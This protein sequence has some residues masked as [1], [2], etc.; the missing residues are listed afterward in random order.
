MTAR[1]SRA[2]FALFLALCFWFAPAYAAAQA[3]QLA[4]VPGTIEGVSD[5]EWNDILEESAFLVED[6]GIYTV[7]RYYELEG[8]VGAP[9]AN[10]VF[11]CVG[12]SQCVADMLYGSAFAF[13]LHV[14]VQT[15]PMDVRVTYRLVDVLSGGVS[16]ESTAVLANP[17]D[18]VAL[19]EPCFQA[20]RGERIAPPPAG[21]P[22]APVQPYPVATPGPTPGPTPTPE[23]TP[24]RGPWIE[25]PP[26]RVSAM[27]LAGRW[28]TAGGAAILATG[29]LIGFAADDTLQT[30]QSVP[31]P[32]GELESLQAQGRSQQLIANVMMGLGGAAMATGITLIIL[33]RPDD[34]AQVSIRTN[35]AAGWVGVG[36]R[37]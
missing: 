33:D 3:L 11:A 7:T 26:R 23:P 21:M 2:M 31:H 17:T 16:G 12:E 32:R 13:A 29:V 20:L 9:L 30:I 14:S 34:G 22:V 19:R 10:S 18:F 27:G 4:V 6:F 35:P 15:S 8:A 24:G 1:F 37:F 25:E 5:Q 36:G 28:T